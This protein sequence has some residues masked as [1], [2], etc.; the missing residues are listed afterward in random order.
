MAALRKE[1]AALQ[2][3]K[4]S[5]LTPTAAPQQPVV[6]VEGETL[7]GGVEGKTLPGG[8]EGEG[9]PQGVVPGAAANP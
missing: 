6:D 2:Y 8:A 5:L 3:E 9:T 7:P 4:D 1:K